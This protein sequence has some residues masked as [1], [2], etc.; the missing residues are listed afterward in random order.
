[1]HTLLGR[2]GTDAVGPSFHQD[3][4]LVLQRGNTPDTRSVDNPHA[5]GIYLFHIR[6]ADY[7]R[8]I[9]AENLADD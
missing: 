1:M 3:G 7:E 8:L 2:K 9:T 4:M 5:L 6:V